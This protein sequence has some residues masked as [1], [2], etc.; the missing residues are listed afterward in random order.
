MHHHQA[1][2]GYG[3]VQKA[4]GAGVGRGRVVQVFVDLVSQDPGAGAAAVGQDGALFLAAQ[5]PAGGVVGRIQD[6]QLGAGANA[7]QQARQIQRPRARLGPCGL[8]RER[9]RLQARAHDLRLRREVGPH[10]CDGHHTVVRI[11]QGLHCQHQRIDAAR[12]HGDALHGDGCG[13]GLAGVHR[14]HGV[15]NGLAQLGQAQVVRIK[16]L[17]L[18]Q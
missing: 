7:V 1:V 2:L 14:R 15:G 17:A 4:G 3:D 16:S 18:L 10:G 6:E 13:A 11:D 8:W 9:H 5:G 12:G